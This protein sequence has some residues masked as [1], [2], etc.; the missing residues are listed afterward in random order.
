MDTGSVAVAPRNEAPRVIVIGNAKGGTGKSTV[1]IHLAVALLYKGYEVGVLDLD[2]DQ[3]TVTRYLA[4]RRAWRSL[5]PL[6][7]SNAA[8]QFPMPRQV[9]LSGSAARSLLGEEAAARHAVDRALAALS[10]R[11]F[12]IVDTPG[13]FSA[14]SQAG[15]ERADVLVT[16]INDS[17]VDIDVLAEID[18]ASRTVIAPSRYSR[19][20]MDLRS[21]AVE[22]GRAS[23][24]WLVIC[25]RRPHVYSHNRR[26][27]DRLME[28]LAD[29]LE[30]R[31]APGLGERVAFREHFQTG[32]TV[33][34]LAP[35]GIQKDAAAGR[36]VAGEEL[37]ALADSIVRRPRPARPFDV[38]SA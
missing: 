32:L 12:V 31:S 9:E 33:M 14:L 4:N 35:M 38:M 16:P 25:N 23:L 10:D 37:W 34:D 8:R 13:S 2:P 7:L 27:I 29:R 26:E 30:F 3:G 22:A 36:P 28:K 5:D 18:V 20:V 6:M 21:K 1:A 11:D 24:D 19:M 15:H 17:F